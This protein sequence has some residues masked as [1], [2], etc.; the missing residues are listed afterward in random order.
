[1]PQR[2]RRVP[3]RTTA[4]GT[5]WLTRR[6]GAGSP[7]GWSVDKHGQGC[8][9]AFPCP[10]DTA[11]GAN[12]D[13]PRSTDP[14]GTRT[15]AQCNTRYQTGARS[16][17]GPHAGGRAGRELTSGPPP[18]AGSLR[19]GTRAQRLQ[20]QTHQDGSAGTAVGRSQGHSA[21]RLVSSRSPPTGSTDGEGRV[22][23]GCP[24]TGTP[25]RAGI[26]GAPCAKL[27]SRPVR[28]LFRAN[29]SARGGT[30]HEAR[31]W[32]PGRPRD[33]GTRARGPA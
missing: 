3:P 30:R 15:D 8:G 7:P 21:P 1:M 29:A 10:P 19:A 28:L 25:T 33:R 31:L 18:T 2:G 26:L 12:R 11:T 22:R 23:G 16:P 20:R 17:P 5:A 24:P 4:P 13:T 6:E 14:P 9:R 27:I 32:G